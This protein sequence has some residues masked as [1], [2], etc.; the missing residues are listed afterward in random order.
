MLRTEIEENLA[1]N[2]ERPVALFETP[3]S[4]GG[5]LDLVGTI[6]AQTIANIQ[7]AG[8]DVGDALADLAAADASKAAGR[9][10]KAYDQYREAYQDAAKSWGHEDHHGRNK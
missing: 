6:V 1:G 4:Q 2:R 10:K 5:Y 9:F 8:G 3:T 7:S